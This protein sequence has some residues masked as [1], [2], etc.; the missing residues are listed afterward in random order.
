MTDS[1]PATSHDEQSIGSST[2]NAGRGWGVAVAMLALAG[3]GLVTLST[4]RYGAG[5]SPDSVLY[6]DGARSLASGKGLTLHSGQP[7]AAA[8]PLY[9]MLLGFVGS[10][11]RLDPTAFAYLLNALLFALVICLSARLLREGP[12]QSAA[13]SLLGLCAVLFSRPLSEVYAMAWSE[14]LFIPLLLLYLLF[15]QRYWDGRGMLSLAAMTLLTALACLTRYVGVALVPAGVTTIILASPG[16]FRRR[17]SRAF[18]FAALSLLPLGLWAA[19]NYR[20]TETLF[21]DRGPRT[22]FT[23]DCI[24]LY[25]KALLGWYLPGH[26][27]KFFVLAGVAVVLVVLVS[28]RLA[29]G[30]AWGGLKTV[31]VDRPP[32]VLLLATYS[33]TLFVASTTGAAIDSRMLS[34]LYVV[35]TLVLLKLAHDLLSSP[36]PISSAVA[37]KLP[38]VLLSLW[39]CFPLTS[40]T[41]SAVGRFKD[42]AGGYNTK[43]WRESETIAHAKQTLSITGD[44]LYSNGP[45]VLWVL[46]GLT[47]TRSPDRRLGDL[48]DLECCWPS[49]DGAVLVWFNS[50]T[51]RNYLFS[52]EEIEEVADVVE[53]AQFNDGAIYRVSVRPTAVHDTS[54]PGS[55][56]PCRP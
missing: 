55:V 29:R 10:V 18:V 40:T 19:R 42:G 44:R 39:L 47:A 20:L 26:G 31:L 7:L 36:R 17:C 23:V 33:V 16:R 52:I 49:Q 8:A 11:T 41:L 48:T 14:V 56:L 21:G 35:L 50:I 45:E 30:R 2:P 43:K 15:S 51:W 27:T 12:R 4:A 34:P 32:A 25:A 46:A 24:I 1:E 37:H 5:I 54:P 53:V 28:S 22:R 9:P 6:L 13:Y 38:P 3:A